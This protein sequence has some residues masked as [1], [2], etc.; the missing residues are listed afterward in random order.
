MN[1]N[2]FIQLLSNSIL[3]FTA[4]F[5][6]GTSNIQPSQEKPLRKVFLGLILGGVSMLIMYNAVAVGEAIYDT[7]TVLL[8]IVG[9]FFP[10][11]TTLTAA[12]VAFAY[13]VVRGGAGVY[14]G[15]FSIVS[16]ALI[17]YL[18]RKFVAKNAHLPRFLRLYLLGFFATLFM[19]LSQLALPEATRWDTIRTIVFPVMLIYPFVTVFVGTTIHHQIDRLEA[20]ENIRKT[21]YL[22]QASLDSPENASIFALDTDYCYLFFNRFHETFMRIHDKV[23]IREGM[24]LLDQ[25]EDEADRQET[26]ANYDRAIAG[27]TFSLFR[28][29]IED[30]KRHFYRNSYGPIHDDTGKIVGMSVIG[31][32]ITTQR[33]TEEKLRESEGKTRELISKMKQGFAHYEIVLDQN[34]QPVDYVVLD[35]NEAFAELSGFKK[36]DV[37]GKRITQILPGVD[38]YW[39]HLYAKVALTGVPF[40]MEHFSPHIKK[41]VHLSC[42][43]PKPMQFATIVTDITDRVKMTHQLQESELRLRRAIEEAPIAV[44]IHAEDGAIVHVNN[45]WCEQT[46]YAKTDLKTISDWLRL[47]YGKIPSHFEEIQHNYFRRDERRFDGE[48]EIRTKDGRTLIWEIYSAAIGKTDDDLKLVMN[49]AFDVTERKQKDQEILFLSYHD[50]LTGLYNRRFYDQE[51]WRLRQPKHAPVSVIMADINGL[52]ITNDAFGHAAGDQLLLRIRDLFLKYKQKDEIICRTGGD[53]FVFLLPQTPYEK[54]LQKIDVMNQELEKMVL[55]GINISVSFGV[56]TKTTQLDFE[57]VVSEA[58]I[59]MYNKKLFEVSS[60][61]SETVKTIMNTLYLKS[62]R[63][64]DHAQAV[65]ELAVQIGQAMGMRRDEVN[66]LRMM[67][68]IH[69]IGKIAVDERI[70]NKAEP[71]TPEEWIDIKRHPEIGYRI[72]SSSAEYA[73]IAGD[74]LAHHERWDGQGYPKG[75][76]GEAIPLRARIIAV[77]ESYQAMTTSRPYREALTP[78]EAVREICRMAGKQFDPAIAQRFVEIVKGGTC[79]CEDVQDR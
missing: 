3:L 53:E 24:N 33:E 56:A 2:I 39:I 40:E 22:L 63:E 71:L 79:P 74:I 11:W 44:M 60:K 4:T 1:L 19:M 15:M 43:S 66:L 49:V 12:V 48:F 69:D 45:T 8:S 62:A 41:H 26:K 75:I 32:D 52:K 20:R 21:R 18:W 58:E 65:G 77:A 67:G 23:K 70:L 7:R 5:V 46:G 37:L 78:E 72:L 13:R 31:I 27:E 14:A 30:G 38:R 50:P 59:D 6:Y 16:A 61:R 64:E 34:S 25:I 57:D 55:N 51:L 54:A 42:Y 36:A 47:A 29:F 17:G 35:I 10:G 76:A 73:Q 9:G 68:Q 28:E